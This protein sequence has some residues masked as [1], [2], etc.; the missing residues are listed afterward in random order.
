M[1]ESPQ[2]L[3]C[4]TSL[5]G[6]FMLGLYKAALTVAVPRGCL[7]ELLMEQGSAAEVTTLR[8]EEVLR[9]WYHRILLIIQ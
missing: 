6:W 3:D 4:S 7:L 2:R 1:S 9:H 5:G 8:E